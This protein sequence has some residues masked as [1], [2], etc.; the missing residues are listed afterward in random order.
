MSRGVDPA[1]N[2][3]Y[4]AAMLES[5]PPLTFGTDDGRAAYREALQS[6]LR[7]ANEKLDMQQFVS[8]GRHALLRTRG[9]RPSADGM[10]EV[11]FTNS[12]ERAGGG[13]G[14]CGQAPAT[15][16]EVRGNLAMQH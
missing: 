16:L 14:G 6:Q 10:G 2:R 12:G 8:Q 15:T 1:G 7:S 3:T 5:L 4:T 11:R 13:A 9:T